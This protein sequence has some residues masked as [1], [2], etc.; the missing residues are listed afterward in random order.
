MIGISLLVTLA[1]C[2]NDDGKSQ[3]NSAQNNNIRSY[4]LDNVE[5]GY[6][7]GILLTEPQVFKI[8]DQGQWDEFWAR[9]KSN[10]LPPTPPPPVDF[11]RFSIIAV[12]DKQQLTGGFSLEITALTEEGTHLNVLVT[13]REPGRSCY[14]TQALTR[15][16]HIIRLDKTALEPQLS[17]TVVV[18]EC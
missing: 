5:K 16:F 10:F 18:N 6:L 14:V 2:N 15:P 8:D 9:H 13:R 12:V 11:S 3:D 7:S 1:A 17:L 4:A